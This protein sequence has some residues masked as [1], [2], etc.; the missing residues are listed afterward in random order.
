MKKKILFSLLAGVM[1]LTWN[2]IESSA[3]A[4]CEN[5]RCH[6]VG[7]GYCLPGHQISLRSSCA[8]ELACLIGE[9]CDWTLDIDVDFE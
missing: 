2:P 8:S 6:S 1:A 9:G 7:M 3:E 4:S 5:H